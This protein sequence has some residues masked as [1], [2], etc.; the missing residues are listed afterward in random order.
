M[1]VKETAQYLTLCEELRGYNVSYDKGEPIISDQ[2]YDKKIRTVHR[3]LEKQP[4]LIDLDQFPNEIGYLTSEQDENDVVLPFKMY[5]TDN[6][7]TWEEFI[8]W[9]HKYLPLGKLIITEK[10]DGI[11]V[12]LTVKNG[13]LVNVSTRGNGTI[14]KAM[15][16]LKSFFK[17]INFDAG[18]YAVHG[19]WIAYRSIMHVGTYVNL[20][21]AAN[22]ARAKIRT[23]PGLKSHVAFKAYNIVDPAGSK[24]YD[25]KLSRLV[26]MGF[27]TCNKIDWY[28]HLMGDNVMKVMYDRLARLYNERHK[29]NYDIDGYVMRYADQD[30]ED[31]AGVTER[32]KHGVIAIKFQTTF[33]PSVIREIILTVGEKGGDAAVAIVDPVILNG[34]KFDRAKVPTLTNMPK[35]GDECIIILS[36][37]TVPVLKMIEHS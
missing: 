20:R 18:D 15:N 22:S 7:Y 6:L 35:V 33:A 24:D 32:V 26:Q 23:K 14:G 5:S 16:H 3:L 36:G 13:K 29:L 2:E 19:E 10:N 37:G 4:S 28:A 31:A 11:A 25:T 34:A 21:S 1:A 27:E 12:N 17:H 9:V 30:L 8:A